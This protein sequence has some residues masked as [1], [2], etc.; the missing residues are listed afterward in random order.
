VYVGKKTGLEANQKNLS[1]CSCFVVVNQKNHDVKI[2][3]TCL[4]EVIILID[5]GTTGRK[6][7]G[8]LGK[9]K[10]KASDQIVYRVTS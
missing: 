2:T 9:I 4:A 3:N 10:K 1:V 5:S 6:E 7:K 8:G